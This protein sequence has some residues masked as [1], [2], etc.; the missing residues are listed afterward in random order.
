M[1]HF[2]QS[3][4]MLWMMRA[5]GGA[6][7]SQEMT[8][9]AVDPDTLL[10]L[11]VTQY[12][13]AVQS[14]TDTTQMPITANA[15]GTWRQ[16]P[17]RHWVS[18]FFP[19]ILWLLYDYTRD[20]HWAQQAR[21]WNAALKSEQFNIGT[22]DLGFMLYNSFG[23][24]YRLTGDENYRA[25]LLRGAASLSS[26]FNPMVGTI[27]SW[28]AKPEDHLTII[29]NMMNLEYLFW[30][31]K[32]T[33]NS[34]YRQIA[35]THANMTLKNHLRADFSSW[36]VVNY[37]PQTGKI[38]QKRTSQGLAD[39]STWARGQAWGAYGFTMMYRETKDDRYLNAA[40]Q[41]F[42]WFISRLPADAVPYWDF[43]APHV[44][45]EPREASAAA[46]AAAGLLELSTYVT[47][48][49]DR[50]RYFEA[51]LKLLQAL[52]SA[53]Y[54]ANKAAYQC[55][56]LHSNGSVPAG[57]DVDVNFTYADYYF[58]EALLRLKRLLAGEPVISQPTGIR[59]ER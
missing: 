47:N 4:V 27:K 2:Q 1:T 15:D 57:V 41:M 55:L 9:T 19:G 30:A 37:D 54:L 42:D 11:A 24:G 5:L 23:H 53:T 35:I 39:S 8:K 43:N 46:I 38:K 32:I 44:P 18:G 50:N 26:R 59:P 28:N 12:A 10:H 13:R 6:G 33:G 48:S 29:D 17:T 20:P 22:H 45:N 31:S 51:A 52:A 36:H 58:I 25:I 16:V 14:L 40:R 3:V 49:Q 34:L 21:R 56:L 7:W